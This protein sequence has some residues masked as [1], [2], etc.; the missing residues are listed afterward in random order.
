MVNLAMPLFILPFPRVPCTVAEGARCTLQPILRCPSHCSSC[1]AA[2]VLKRQRDAAE[3]K[4]VKAERRKAKAEAE[5]C[6]GLA[7]CV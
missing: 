3:L 4:K 2:E 7:G 5:V 1:V 6:C